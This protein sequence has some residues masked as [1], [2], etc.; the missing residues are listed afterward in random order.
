[1]K[2]ESM[3]ITAGDANPTKASLGGTKPTK[4][5]IIRPKN[6]VRSTGKISVRKRIIIAPSIKK[7]N[8][9]SMVI[10]N[11]LLCYFGSNNYPQQGYSIFLTVPAG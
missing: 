9:I 11:S 4:I 8:P 2:I 5:K 10:N 6:A 3:V 1:M 7:R